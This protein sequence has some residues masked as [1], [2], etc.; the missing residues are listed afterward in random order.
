MTWLGGIFML[1][2]G[3]QIGSPS[4]SHAQH[5]DKS[6]SARSATLEPKK[7]APLN[8]S[9][10]GAP[11]TPMANTLRY[12]SAPPAAATVASEITQW[13][14]YTLFAALSRDARFTVSP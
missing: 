8:E 9:Q 2:R 10:G 7:R 5:A 4:R 12:M 13:L 3:Q 11:G 1:G 14:P 6:S